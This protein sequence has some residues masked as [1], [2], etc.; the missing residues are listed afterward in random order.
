MTFTDKAIDR[1][2]ADQ[3]RKVIRM[4]KIGMLFEKEKEE[5]VMVLGL[6]DGSVAVMDYESEYKSENKVK[7]LNYLT[8]IVN[9][10]ENQK[11]VCPNLRMIVIYTG[12]IRREEATESY[13]VGAVRL[14][15]E[16][17]FLSEVDGD[18]TFRRLMEKVESRESLSDQEQM[19]LCLF[20]L[21]YRKK[22]EKME[23]IWEAVT[24]AARI[25]D[26]EQQAF[27][28]SG[29]MIFTDKVIDEDMADQMR[30]VIRMTKIG[31]LFEKEKEEAVM[32]ERK[33][34]EKRLKEECKKILK[35][36]M[37]EK[38]KS[39]IEML[40]DELPVAKIVRYSGL[41]MATVTEL[42]E[43]IS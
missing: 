36:Q 14:A 6:A 37:E 11:R 23:R 12:D 40:H 34:A 19:E 25:A 26:Q 15:I 5:P 13:D 38:K 1:E 30:K 28:L 27:V 31:M 43:S 42:A 8:G 7:Y 18:G 10:Y 2:M 17:V 33:K 20:P 35:E 41:D 21:T 22:E 4:T 39:A 32:E 16:P 9:R 3:I 24:L 29:I